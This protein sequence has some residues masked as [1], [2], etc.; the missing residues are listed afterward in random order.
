[1]TAYDRFHAQEAEDYKQQ[2]ISALED[3]LGTIESELYKVNSILEDYD[4]NGPKDMSEKI[5]LAMAKVN[6]IISRI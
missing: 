4:P 5:E 2:A 1:L 3:V 6:E